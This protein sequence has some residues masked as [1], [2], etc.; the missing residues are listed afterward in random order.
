MKTL[1]SVDF[2]VLIE[3]GLS[4]TF[5]LPLH[6]LIDF[7]EKTFQV[8]KLYVSPMSTTYLLKQ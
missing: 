1:E 5:K 8:I 4:D 3:K 7:N 6:H 2:P